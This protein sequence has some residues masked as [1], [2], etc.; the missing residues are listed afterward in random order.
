MDHVIVTANIGSA[1]KKYALYSGETRLLE[2]HLEHDADGYLATITTGSGVNEEK[3]SREQFDQAAAFVLGHLKNHPAATA[4]GIRVV[5]PGSYFTVH[6]RIDDEYL[7]RLARAQDFAP[8]HVG[9]TLAEILE[10]KKIFPE[11]LLIGASD[12]AFHA[13]MPAAARRY[14]LPEPLVK[15]YELYRYGYHGLSIGSVVQKLTGLPGGIPQRTIVCHL[16]SGSSV[17]ALRNGTSVD[18]S[19]GYSPLEGLPMATRSGSIDPGIVIL[20]AEKLSLPPREIEKKLNSDSGLL[21]L[22]GLSA[23]IRQLL[24]AE[25]KGS[26]AAKLA[27][28]LFAYRVRTAIG[29]YAAALGGVDALIFTGT[30]GER[31]AVMRERITEGLEFLKLSL[32]TR[33]NNNMLGGVDAVISKPKGRAAIHVIV[34]DEAQAI[35]EITHS[36]V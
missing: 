18:T 36:L 34:A 21:G 14:A 31:S 4:I 6:R 19:M 33:T 25:K 23:D 10:L 30:V 15:E 29:A 16:G 26:E 9:A 35:S 17:T 8:L 2:A 28:D 22:S 13:A 12:S 11:T 24:K 27:L 1:S 32:A 20:L 3:I 5:A 7:A